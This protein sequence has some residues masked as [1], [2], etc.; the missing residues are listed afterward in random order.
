METCLVLGFSV[1]FFLRWKYWQKL[2][3]REAFPG[4]GTFIM[5]LSC[6]NYLMSNSDRHIPRLWLHKPCFLSKPCWKNPSR[7]LIRIWDFQ[8]LYNIA[9][10]FPVQLQ[11]IYRSL[12]LC[13]FRVY[14]YLYEY[15]N[16]CLVFHVLERNYLLQAADY[17]FGCLC[18][19]TCINFMWLSLL[20]DSSK[21]LKGAE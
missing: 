16:I 14:R 17:Q 10:A 6:V 15:K 7:I 1:F 5:S 3:L 18:H 9:T 20:H 11:N 8:I 19:W 2:F 4:L 13:V 21:M 12:Y